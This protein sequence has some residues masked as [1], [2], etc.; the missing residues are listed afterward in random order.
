MG[1]R[2]RRSLLA[3]ALAVPS[4]LAARLFPFLGAVGFALGRANGWGEG[5]A[6]IAGGCSRRGDGGCGG[7]CAKG[8]GRRS[9]GRRRG[10]GGGRSQGG[11]SGVRREGR[12]QGRVGSR[13]AHG[14]GEI[15]ASAHEFVASAR[16]LVASA[17]SFVA[18]ACAFVAV[19]ACPGALVA[20]VALEDEDVARACA[21]FVVGGGG[22]GACACALIAVVV[23]GGAASARA[24]TLITTLSGRSARRAIVVVVAVVVEALAGDR[25]GEQGAEREAGRGVYDPGRKLRARSRLGACWISLGRAVSCG[26]LPYGGPWRRDPALQMNKLA[27]VKKLECSAAAAS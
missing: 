15:V 17:R 8:V 3:L 11:A 4:Q 7:R 18:V 9:R 20:A 25:I 10:C 16:E 2:V 27:G 12:A 26:D 6:G 1:E 5:L 13:S 23:L 14:A 19:A 24:R 22:E 21:F